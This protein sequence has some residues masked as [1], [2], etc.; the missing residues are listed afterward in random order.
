VIREVCRCPFCGGTLAVD[1]D[2]PEVVFDTDRPGSG[3]FPLA[4]PQ[5]ITPDRPP[6]LRTP[7]VITADARVERTCCRRGR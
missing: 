7:C 3:A 2:V 1:D 5:A 6:L 4:G